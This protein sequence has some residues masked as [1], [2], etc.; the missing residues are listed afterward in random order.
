MRQ[1]LWGAIATLLAA[2]NSVEDV[3]ALPV[4]WSGT[5]AASY[6]VLANCMATKTMAIWT[7]V[8]PMVYP[9]E[10]RAVVISSSQGGSVL[11]EFDIRQVTPT[12]S[13]MQYRQAF[14]KSPIV[15]DDLAKLAGGC[16]R[17]A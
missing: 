16:A 8:V 5:Y 1:A 10:Q 11:W 15:G 7:N 3:H 17:P 12:T 9:S 2:C 14:R 6:D 4:I 13:S